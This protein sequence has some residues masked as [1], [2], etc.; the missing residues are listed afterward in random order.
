MPTS[1]Q[2]EIK[3]DYLY[4]IAKGSVDSLDEMLAHIR[5]VHAKLAQSGLLKLLVNDT[6]CHM[7]LN[8]DGIATVI[9]EAYEQE[10]LVKQA[11]V[12]AVSSPIN[13]PILQ[14]TFKS[15]EEVMIFT[16]EKDAEVWLASK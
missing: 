9:K 5:N 10:W 16:D 6:Q 12:A 11:R 7:H 13:F 4:V 3:G 1:Y 14:H 8:I 2:S 15:T